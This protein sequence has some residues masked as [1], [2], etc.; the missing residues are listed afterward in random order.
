MM[1]LDLLVIR[2]TLIGNHF[3]KRAPLWLLQWIKLIEIWLSIEKFSI[4]TS[5]KQV[6]HFRYLVKKLKSYDLPDL[7]GAVKAKKLPKEALRGVLPRFKLGEN[8]KLEL[9]EPVESLKENA[10]K[11]F[12]EYIEKNETFIAEL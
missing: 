12:D 11:A 9:T 10:N 2:L 5:F 7:L 3:H 1:P 4:V 6:F 8:E